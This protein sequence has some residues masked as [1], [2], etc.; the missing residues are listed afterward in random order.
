MAMQYKLN[1]VMG[2]AAIGVTAIA[3]FRIAPFQSIAHNLEPFFLFRP[4]R[5]LSTQ[6]P[7]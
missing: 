6:S 4:K 3:N 2:G 5:I 1:R 7:L